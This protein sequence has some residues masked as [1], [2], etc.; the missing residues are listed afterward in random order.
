MPYGYFDTSKIFK[1]YILVN[2]D[3]SPIC[4]K[5]H[6]WVNKPE[7]YVTL[8]EARKSDSYA[9]I[10]KEGIVCVDVD[11]TEYANKLL[12]IIKTEEISTYAYRTTKGIHFYFKEPSCKPLT[13]SSKHI[14]LACGLMKTDVFTGRTN[15]YLIKKL[16]GK[17]RENVLLPVNGELDEMPCWLKPLKGVVDGEKICEDVEYFHVY[18]LEEGSR[19][20][21]MFEKA[22]RFAFYATESVDDAKETCLIINRHMLDKPLSTRE[23]NTILRTEAFADMSHK[24]HKLNDNEKETIVS[25]RIRMNSPRNIAEIIKEKYAVRKVNGKL[26]F[27]YE[28]NRIEDDDILMYIIDAELGP[29]SSIRRQDEVKEN[30]RRFSVKTTYSKHIIKVGGRFFD[31]KAKVFRDE[32]VDEI[33]PAVDV[34]HEYKPDA[35]CQITDEFLDTVFQGNKVSRKLF[36]RYLS[37]ILIPNNKRQKALSLIGKSGAGKSTLLNMVMHLIGEENTVHHTLEDFGEKFGLSDIKDKALCLLDDVTTI[38]LDNASLKSFNRVVSGQPISVDTK[39]GRASVVE[40][41]CKVLI[42]AND[43]TPV[44]GG[45]EGWNRRIVK[46]KMNKVLKWKDEYNNLFS[47]ESYEYLLKL[48]LEELINTTDEEFF[49]KDSYNEINE[50]R[51]IESSIDEMNISEFLKKTDLNGLTSTEVSSLFSEY[52][53]NNHIHSLTYRKLCLYINSHGYRL[54]SKRINGKIIRVY[55]RVPN[56]YEQ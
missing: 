35:Y 52:V 31:T 36:I 16:N 4:G 23:I 24:G 27:L 41:R 53:S 37:Y 2:S 50:Q 34:P 25:E 15:K 7:S 13:K 12:D 32:Y 19:N 48:A 1:G 43:D 54:K 6:S 46:I 21:V 30:L 5:G 20:T 18:G 40:P 56:T 17:E 44:E 28:G 8:S 55:E 49:G 39:F 11:N 9:G 29:T 26:S 14:Q 51:N 38:M 47:E 10:L 42:S 33:I 3:K 45:S 22:R